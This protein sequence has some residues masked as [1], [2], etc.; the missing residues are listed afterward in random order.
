LRFLLQYSRDLV[1]FEEVLTA[2]VIPFLFFENFI[3][4]ALSGAAK[5][6]A[7]AMARTFLLTPGGQE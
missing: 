7:I 5:Q 2:L 6:V 3:L 4:G 1:F